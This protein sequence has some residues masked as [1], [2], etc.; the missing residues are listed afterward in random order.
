MASFVTLVGVDNTEQMIN[1][2]L[3]TRMIR[4]DTGEGF[5]SIYFDNGNDVRVRET[6]AQIL[7]GFPESYSSLVRAKK[8]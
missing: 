3:I 7:G 1:V 2:D 8:P 5:T 6:P 4:H